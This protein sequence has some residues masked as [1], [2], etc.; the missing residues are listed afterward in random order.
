[1]GAAAHGATV[2]LGHAEARAFGGDQ[3]VRRTAEADTAAEDEA[4]H[5]DDHRF[6]IAVD[7]LEAVV[8]ALVHRDYQVAVGGQ[9]LDV[10][11]GA[12]AASLGSDEDDI[13]LGRFT[14]SLQLSGDGRPALAVEGIHR[15]MVEDHLGDAVVDAHLKWIAHPATP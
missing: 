8:V 6:G 1:M 3:D 10:H 13:H 7:G 15:R 11:A 5:G 14:Q 4:M 9:F 2:H 12:E